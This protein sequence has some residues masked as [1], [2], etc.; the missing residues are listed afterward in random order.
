M[1]DRRFTACA[2]LLAW[3]PLNA[4]ARPAPLASMSAVRAVSNAE[5]AQH[6]P[7]SFQ[8]TVTYYR[9]YEDALFVQDGDL[10]IYVKATTPLP[11]QPGDRILI[12]GVMAPSFNPIVVSGAITLL[13]HGPLPKSLAASYDQMLQGVLDCR[14]ITVRAVV[15]SSDLILS[16]DRKSGSLQL[17]SD[18]GSYF[19]AVDSDDQNALN[20]LLGA[21]IEATGVVSGRF[22]GK[23][24]RTGIMLHISRLAD[25]KVLKPAATSPWE[26]PVTPMDQIFPGYRVYDATQ[27]FRVRGVITYYQPGYAVVLQNGVRSLWLSTQN[28]D[29]LRIGDVV[30]ATGFPDVHSGFL[31]L[32]DSEIRDSQ[33]P[34]PIA[35]LPATW[36]QLASSS[37]IFD[38]VSIE[39]RVVTEVRAA[40]QDEYVLEADG[41]HFT[42]V[43]R[44]P[45]ATSLLPVPPMK[46]IPVGAK[47]RVTGICIPVFSNPFDY[48]K[49]FNILIRSFDD[50]AVV[51][52]PPVFNSRTLMLT[53][54]L[55]LAV[56]LAVSFWGWTLRHKVRQQTALITARIAAEAETERRA[57]ILEQRRSRI[58]EDI[59]GTQ[60]LPEILKEITE[61]VSLTLNGVPCW[62]ETAEGTPIGLRPSDAQETR[63][64]REEISARN[65][66]PLGTLHAALGPQNPI[67][68]T[69]A[70]DEQAEA[71]AMGARLATLAI[72]TRSMY[73]DLTRRTQFDLL[74][75]VHNRFSMETQLELHIKAAQEKGAVFGLIYIDLDDFKQVND[76][77]GHRAGDL[78]LQQAAMRMKRQLRGGDMLA[79]LGGD[80]CAALVSASHTRAGVEDV[81][82]R[83]ERCFDEPFTVDGNLL[84]GSPSL[85]IALYPEDGVTQDGLLSAADAAMYAAKNRKREMNKNLEQVHAKSQSPEDRK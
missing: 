72:E 21:E 37:N 39:G 82:R 23:M 36:K 80:E 13:H 6:Q 17:L 85:G 83:L 54:G 40:S 61:L 12:K 76:L 20:G 29:P 4:T 79:R 30:D 44:H 74:T 1:I 75:D 10:S 55:L 27:R 69:P 59:N 65:G 53:V 35:P 62:C 73:A 48:D 19:A 3:I 84:Y 25:I 81:A 11:L 5:A 70:S 46:V 2:A 43:Y 58:L 64:I 7:V 8:A 22:D 9:S 71:L 14:L 50:I 60:P 47:I 77:Y 24:Q 45:A 26:L 63:I 66:P 33:L 42:A 34:A 78:Y 68:E 52:N 67:G 28:R 38:L 16:S 32:T 51:A 31:S 15:R 57:A 18:G 49:A 41:R 56:V